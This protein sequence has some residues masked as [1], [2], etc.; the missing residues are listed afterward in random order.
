MHN[1]FLYTLLLISLSVLVS[2]LSVPLGTCFLI[3][4]ILT[5]SA[6]KAIDR[7]Y[8]YL[9]KKKEYASK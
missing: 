8:G 7:K 2:M 4:S 3:L 1:S 9:L 5:V 6:K